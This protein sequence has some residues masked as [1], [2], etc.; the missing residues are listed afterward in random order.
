MSRDTMATLITRVRTR[1][2][3]TGSPPV[4]D[5]DVIENTL[6]ARRL[7]ARQILL[8][9]QPLFTATGQQ[10]LDYYAEY[11]DWEDGAT[12]YGPAF[13]VLTP[14]AHDE[15]TGHWTFASSTLPPVYLVGATYDVWGAAADLLEMWAT[16]L[17]L[18]FDFSAD[19]ASFKLSQKQAALRALATSYRRQARAGSLPLVRTERR[20]LPPAGTRPGR[21]LPYPPY[22]KAS[23]G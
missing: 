5:D 16:Q 6:D 9:P 15:L 14:S 18:E 19:G 1:I 23:T 12:L 7:D 4:F 10:F 21:T 22:V 11:G 20:G 2:H 17:A 8:T 13:A 3:D